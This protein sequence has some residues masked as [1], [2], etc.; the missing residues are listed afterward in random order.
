MELWHCEHKHPSKSDAAACARVRAREISAEAI[1]KHQEVLEAMEPLNLR[2]AL[3][4]LLPEVDSVTLMGEH[5]EDPR[6]YRL[7]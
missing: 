3:R 7:R 4:E 2:A 5:G 6:E 1:R